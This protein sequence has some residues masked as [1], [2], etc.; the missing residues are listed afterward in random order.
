MLRTFC[1]TF[2]Q[3]FLLNLVTI[4]FRFNLFF[5]GLF[6]CSQQTT[7]LIFGRDLINQSTS[8]KSLALTDCLPKISL[9]KQLISCNKCVTA[10]P[11]DTMLETCCLPHFQHS[12]RMQLYLDSEAHLSLLISGYHLDFLPL[13]L[14]CISSHMSVFSVWGSFVQTRIAFVSNVILYITFHTGKAFINRHFN[15]W[16]WKI[17]PESGKEAFR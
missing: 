14:S 7:L 1:C 15:N 3:F 5:F 11:S 9:K 16:L 12:K 4:F 2:L 8:G 6:S 13:L 10:H 17:P